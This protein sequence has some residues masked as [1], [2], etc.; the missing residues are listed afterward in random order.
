MR[1]AITL[2]ALLLSLTSIVAAQ[3]QPLALRLHLSNPIS[4]TIVRMWLLSP[5]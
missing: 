4:H 2:V 3:N 5:I 1:Y